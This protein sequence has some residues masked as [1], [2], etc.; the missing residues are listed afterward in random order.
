[1]KS[2]LS[3]SRTGHIVATLCAVFLSL[4]ADAGAA[5]SIDARTL[6]EQQVTVLDL[7]KSA[8]SG[9]NSSKTA[10]KTFLAATIMN[11][12]LQQLCSIIQD[13][14]QYPQFMPNTA[15]TRVVQA[16]DGTFIDLTLSL[17]LGKTK[18]YRLQMES[19]VSDQSCRLAWKLV[20]S[21]LRIEDTIADT[22]GYW[23]LT[24]HPTDN[25]KTVVEY[26]VYADPG[27]VPFGFGW[28]VDMMSKRSLPRTLE[29]VRERAGTQQ[30]ASQ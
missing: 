28:I 25:R 9:S 26:Q 20:P 16:G 12:P 5:Q 23:Q 18:K 2:L 30:V 7:S 17:P 27:P 14:P 24:P 21:G 15:D 4:H 19:K 22:I 3:S 13:Y 11:A 8:E 10:G 29:A 1:M 6:S